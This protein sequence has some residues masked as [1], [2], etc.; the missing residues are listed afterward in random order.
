M[1]LNATCFVS[2]VLSGIAGVALAVSGQLTHEVTVVLILAAIA[3][4]LP[5]GYVR[6]A[7][8]VG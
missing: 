7:R 1:L 8:A 5:Y 2:G 3:V 6:I 4:W